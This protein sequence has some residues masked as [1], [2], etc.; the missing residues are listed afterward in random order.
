[1]SSYFGQF[2]LV[3]AA[4]SV[5]SNA[6]SRSTYSSDTVLLSKRSAVFESPCGINTIRSDDMKKEVT[7]MIACRSSG[8]GTDEKEGAKMAIQIMSSQQ[9]DKTTSFNIDGV[10]SVDLLP[11]GVPVIDHLAAFLNTVRGFGLSLIHI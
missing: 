3:L 7:R 10:R 2:E 5:Q 1:M 6:R 4:A 8:I 11:G 9:A